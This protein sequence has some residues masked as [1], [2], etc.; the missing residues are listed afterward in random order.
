MA[1]STKNALIHQ[2]LEPDVYPHPCTD[3]SLVETHISWVILTGIYAY[4]IK[5]PVDLGFVDFSTIER[6]RHFCEE[7]L[8]LNRRLA[9][10]LYQEVVPITGSATHPCMGDSGG[11]G[12]AVEYAVRM[13]QFDQDQLLSRLIQHDRVTPDQIDQLAN[14]VATFHDQV[15]VAEVASTFGSPNELF[16][17]VEANFDAILPVLDG[18]EKELAEELQEWSRFQFDRLYDDFAL[19]KISGMIRECHGDMHLGNMFLNPETGD[20]AGRVV[21]FDGIEFNSNLR[22][23]DV[24]SEIAFVVMD[25]EDRGRPDLAHRFLNKWLEYTGDYNGL[26]LLPFYM[27]YRAVVRAKVDAI[28]LAQGHLHHDERQHLNDDCAGYLKLAYKYTDSRRPVM[29]ITNGV[30]GSGKTTGTQ[31]TIERTGAIRVRSDIERKRLFGV[32]PLGNSS[33]S[34]IY[35]ATAT[36]QTYECLADLSKDVI[37]AGY[38]VVV[39]ATFL[40]RERRNRFCRLARCLGVPFFILQFGANEEV[41]R[42]R[43]RQRQQTG[44]DAS[45]ATIDVL[46][47]QLRSAEPVGSDEQSVAITDDEVNWAD[48]RQI[49]YRTSPR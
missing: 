28:R 5:K 21:V 32:K 6:R 1:V 30:S 14:T 8:R 18:A 31:N 13:R 33:D 48:A 7:E 29:M 10:D 43:V 11:N 25:L 15:A 47:R 36:D 44:G 37:Q 49:V 39:D 19:R 24:M 46:D 2:L 3:I 20:S 4:K 40:K 35:T 22:W 23:I 42:E 17:P 45:E 41:L 34:E 27:V 9:P 16:D 38:P 12:R 26:R